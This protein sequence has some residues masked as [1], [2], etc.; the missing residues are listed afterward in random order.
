MDTI[1]KEMLIS[2]RSS[3]QSDMITLMHTFGHNITALE[4]RVSHIINHIE[5]N[6][7]DV[8]TTVKELVD[9]HDDQME[10]CR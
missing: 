3:L 4:K 10:E 7:E 6:V 5:T 2:L 1:L 8:A 9:A